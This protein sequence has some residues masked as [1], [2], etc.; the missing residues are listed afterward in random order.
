MKNFKIFLLLLLLNFV[1][2]VPYLSCYDYN[3]AGRLDPNPILILNPVKEIT[4]HIWKWTEA[5]N[6]GGNT[7]WQ[8]GRILLGPIFYI[9]KL[10]SGIKVRFLFEILFLAVSGFGMFLFTKKYVFSEN[11]AISLFSGLLYIYNPYVAIFLEA[12]FILLFPYLI[13]TGSYKSFQNYPG[14]KEDNNDDCN[15][16]DIKP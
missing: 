12:S 2:F 11:K 4:L 9:L 13:E 7:D 14:K 3:M 10:I 8:T 6:L 15:K 1:I 16:L 5:W